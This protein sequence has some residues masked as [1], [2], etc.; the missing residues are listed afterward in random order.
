[1]IILFVAFFFIS[2]FLFFRAPNKNKEKNERKKEFIAASIL[3]KHGLTFCSLPVS[4]IQRVVDA[5]VSLY[6]GSRPGRHI[7]ASAHKFI[8]N[9]LLIRLMCEP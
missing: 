1:M 3:E 6:L 7:K 5:V 8:F 2:L 4:H 9:G